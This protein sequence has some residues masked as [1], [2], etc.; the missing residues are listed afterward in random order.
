[1]K[2]WL[3]QFTHRHGADTWPR[4]ANKRP[5]AGEEIA[6]LGDTWEGEE[7]GDYLEITGPFDMPQIDEFIEALRLA[8]AAINQ[9][10]RF[11]VRGPLPRKDSYQIAAIID[12]LLRKVDT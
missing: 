4:F 6:E 5:Y 10:P 3:V 7:K 12:A 9:T 2:L 11:N 1:M 8:S